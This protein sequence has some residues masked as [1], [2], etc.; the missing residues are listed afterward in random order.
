[1]PRLGALLFLVL[2]IATCSPSRPS[3]LEK[4]SQCAA[5]GR[6]FIADLEKRTSGSPAITNIRFAYNSHADTCL[7]GYEARWGS[8]GT[9]SEYLIIDLLSN[10]NLADYD[11]T[12]PNPEHMKQYKAAVSAM[13]NDRH[14]PP[15]VD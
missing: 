7:C 2:A 12:V 1:M 5:I 11:T 8:R 13:E 10:R 6:S 3:K 9:G 4:K 14:L 15:F